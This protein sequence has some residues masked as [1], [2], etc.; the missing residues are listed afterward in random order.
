MSARSFTFAACAA[1]LA[2]GPA[3]Q[4]DVKSD[5]LISK[6]RQVAA[7]AKTLQADL[8]LSVP[9]GLSFKGTARLMKPGYGNVSFSGPQG[10]QMMISDGENFYMVSP[11]QK[12]YQKVPVKG[13]AARSLGLLPGSPLAAFLTPD[14]IAAGGTHRFAGIKNV[15]GTT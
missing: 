7:K 8:E 10:A 11:A 12:Q 2:A 5:A 9:G 6:A 13:Q 15:G 4:A 14:A 3:V 1:L